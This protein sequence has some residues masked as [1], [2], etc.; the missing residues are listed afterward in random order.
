MKEDKTGKIQRQKD[1]GYNL[2]DKYLGALAGL[3]GIKP[4]VSMKLEE[5]AALTLLQH[6]EPV[7]KAAARREQEPVAWALAW[8]EAKGRVNAPTTFFERAAAERYV[9][10]CHGSEIKIV[11]LYTA[12]QPTPAPLTPKGETVPQTVENLQA[13]MARDAE[14][15]L[16]MKR[17]ISTLREK[18]NQARLKKR[19]IPEG[20]ALVPVEPTD[21]M[22]DA[23]WPRTAS[24]GYQEAQ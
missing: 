19:P 23:I 2:M 8:P 12:P 9:A 3:A 24:P 11:P 22:I 14:E 18:L 16:R 20:Y 5:L 21:E 10:G 4:E 1:I 15:M 17:Q 6:T 13:I 7:D